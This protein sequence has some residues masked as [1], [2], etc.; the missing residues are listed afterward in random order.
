MGT[1]VEGTLACL[2][3]RVEGAEHVH[4]S[5]DRVVIELD[6]GDRVTVTA[7]PRALGV[8]ATI[9]REGSWAELS[10]SAEARA[11]RAVAPG[12]HVDVEL[13]GWTIATGSRIAV[14]G[15]VTGTTLAGGGP[16]EAATERPAALEAARIEIVRD[17]D[18]AGAIALLERV[19]E[20]P[21]R[22]RT[23]A[24]QRA[25]RP[26]RT[27]PRTPPPP[28]PWRRTAPVM[29]ILGAVLAAPG[30]LLWPR[31]GAAGLLGTGAFLL[32]AALAMYLSHGPFDLGDAQPTVVRWSERLASFLTYTMLLAVLIVPI[33]IFL[34]P[35]A[36]GSTAIMGAVLLVG[37]LRRHRRHLRFARLL[38]GGRDLPAP[39]S[40]GTWGRLAGTVVT[41]GEPV[42][43]RTSRY[44]AKASGVTS[45]QAV[46][47]AG[48]VYTEFRGKSW[49]QATPVTTSRPFHLRVGT[50]GI[51][52]DAAG[53]LWGTPTR[54]IATVEPVEAWATQAAIAEG[55]SVVALGR[56][57]GGTVRATGPESL[58]L[59]GV[60]GWEDA[61]A[62]L[63]RLTLR[64]LALAT[65]LA[66]LVAASL[67][68]AV[69]ATL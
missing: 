48:R 25:P 54:Y 35:V 67:G 55:C 66:A 4:D 56:I 41:P 24:R 69:A 50:Q 5:D 39:W 26:K 7:S 11:F 34:P 19:V 47:S 52:I 8:A 61:R 28:R 64:W 58:L 31:L 14:R 10:G 46:D 9:V 29:A 42:L 13:R 65:A 63:R 38:L 53:A 62:T 15:E 49:I 43:T 18:D 51:E 23:P 60:P 20:E 2:R 68:L 6:G 32:E 22:V 17:G 12:D 1:V 16:R 44:V 21:A 37:A 27:A 36:Y 59:F 45:H 30:L 3:L 40:D 57:D 33:W